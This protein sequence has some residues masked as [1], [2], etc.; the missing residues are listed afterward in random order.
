MKKKQYANIEEPF[1]RL[2]MPTPA[3]EPV[4]TIPKGGIIIWSGLANNI[5]NG[6]ALC[7]GMNGTPDLRGRFVVGGIAG[8]AWYS[9]GNKGGVTD[10]TLQPFN[11]PPHTHSG[12]VTING[13]TEI[14][15]LHEHELDDAYYSEANCGNSGK[16]GSGNSD[17]DNNF[18]TYKHT[19][20]KNGNHNHKFSSTGNFTTNDGNQTTKNQSINILNPYYALA[21]IMKL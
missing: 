17:Y 12:S 7:D 4:V 5:P 9:I 6:W 16:L 11:L 19:T 21:Y 1:M 14:D 2:F 3:P 20:Y 13:T 10:I 8:S 18:C 15:G